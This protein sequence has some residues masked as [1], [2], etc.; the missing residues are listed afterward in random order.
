MKERGIALI[1]FTALIVLI[2][3]PSFAVVYVKWD[4]TGNQAGDSWENACVTVRQGMDKA[5]P[6]DEIWVAEGTYKG[7]ILMKNGVSL[8]GGFTGN[9][10]ERDQRDWATYPAVLISWTGQ[11]VVSFPPGAAED[12]RLDGFT[13]RGNRRPGIACA[14]SSPTIVHNTIMDVDVAIICMLSS[15]IISNNL[16]SLCMM[17]GV[18]CRNS[19]APLISHNIFTSN[20]GSAVGCYSSSPQI[21]N[22]RIV[23]NDARAV[24][25]IWCTRSSP[26]ISGNIFARNKGHAVSC[27]EWSSPVIVC[28]TITQH[29]STETGGPGWGIACEASSPTIYNNIIAFNEGGIGSYWSTTVERNNCVFGN[30][31]DYYG[32]TPDP[33]D[34]PADPLF[35]NAVAD[36]YHILPNSPCVNAGWNEAPGLPEFD[37]D[38]QGRIC[39]GTVDIGADEVWPRLVQID[40]RPGESPNVINL[41]SKGLIPVAVLSSERF[42]AT[43]L[44]PSAIRFAGASVAVRG[45]DRPLADRLDI[46]GDGD[47]DLRVRFETSALTIPAGATSAILAGIGPDGWPIEGKDDIVVVG[48]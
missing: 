16:I 24:S 5:V 26:I 28:N 10:T 39:W 35:V 27:K 11:A 22:N 9:E 43:A 15:P 18:W 38:S 34:I 31:I 2:A 29:R 41:K 6:D 23:G 33:T 37:M 25:G 19:S 48:R 21:L 12:T 8:Y 1:L 3:V 30:T 13:I 32:L 42:D 20:R 45:K 40:I 46:D 17:Y 47:L 36:D 7:P 44:D 4:A 14:I